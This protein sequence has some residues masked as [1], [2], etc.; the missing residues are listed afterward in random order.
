MDLADDRSSTTVAFELASLE[1]LADPTA[2]FDQTKGWARSVGIVSDRPTYVITNAA[3]R[4]DLDYGFHSGRHALVDSLVAI[5]ARPEQAADRYLLIGTTDRDPMPIAERGWAFL[6]ID[7][8]AEAAGWS[9]KHGESE[10]TERSD[11]P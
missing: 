8:A 3:R 10:P 7:E 6:P 11:W 4:W 5:Q 9:L 1:Q 2:V